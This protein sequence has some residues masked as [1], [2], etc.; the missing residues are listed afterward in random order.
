V[1]D[2]WPGNVHGRVLQSLTGGLRVVIG[3][4]G[5]FAYRKN[6]QYSAMVTTTTT[7]TDGRSMLENVAISFVT[8]SLMQREPGC[9][10]FFAKC[11]VLSEAG[12]KEQKTGAL[13]KEPLCQ[14]MYERKAIQMHAEG[15]PEG[16]GHVL[17]D[18]QLLGLMGPTVD[19][20]T[21]TKL[22]PGSNCQD[23]RVIDWSLRI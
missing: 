3:S 6:C 19:S 14:G 7:V 17:V 5:C 10:A 12:P 8:S 15:D 9:S 2:P 16:E 23:V 1:H 21:C 20:T 11:R 22:D 13:S 4:W 18:S